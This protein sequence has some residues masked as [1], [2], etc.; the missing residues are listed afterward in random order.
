MKRALSRVR[1]GLCTAFCGLLVVG[2]KDTG[3]ALGTTAPVGGKVTVDGQPVTDGQVSLV[4]FDEGISTGGGVA[5]GKID[6]AGG[7]K[8]FTAGK[9]GAPLGR[10]KVMVTPSMI[11]TGDSKMPT[12]PFHQKFSDPK[13][14]T[15]VVEV[16]T[17]PSPG[18]YDLK[19]TK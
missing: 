13:K 15:L 2:C 1:F 7:Y 14:T 4:P 6:P 8:I 12:S 19:L 9:D 5:A 18:A 10:Y 11:P 3:P 17:N 16:V